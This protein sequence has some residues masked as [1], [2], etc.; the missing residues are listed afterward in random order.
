MARPSYSQKTSRVNTK[1]LKN[2]MRSIGASYGDNIKQLAPNISEITNAGA[3]T[4]AQVARS[5]RTNKSGTERVKTA[6]SSNKYVKFATTAY[7]N[8]LVDIKTGNFNNTERE[9]SSFGSQISSEIEDTIGGFTFGDDGADNVNV[10]VIGDSGAS[11]GALSKQLADNSAASLQVQKANMDAYVAVSSASMQQV[12]QIG[13]EIVNQLSNV[14]NQL[15]AI[16]QYNNS[17]M[18]K[19]IEASMA[20]MER[21][22]SSVEKMSA[23]GGKDD[24]VSAM[25]VI[26]SGTK[27]GINLGRYKQMVKQQF[28][29]MVDNSEFGVL[30]TLLDD[31]MFMQQLASNPLAGLSRGLTSYMTPKIL[32]ST[33]ENM[34]TTFNNMSVDIASQLADLSK[35]TSS[36]FGG[37]L[38]R[39]IGETFGLKVD[40][41]NTF[42]GAK[43][44]RGAIPFDGETKHAITEIITKELRTQT[45]YLEIIA[46]HY[47][48]NAKSKAKENAEVWDWDSNSYIKLGSITDKITEQMMSTITSTMSDSFFGSN[49]NGLIDQQKNDKAKKD[50]ESTINELYVYMEK[51]A[52][53]LSLPDLLNYVQATN[54]SKEAKRA[55]KNWIKY[56]KEQNP[57]DFNSRTT[58]QISTQ[59]AMKELRDE[60]ANNPTYYHLFDSEYANAEDIDEIFLEQLG[61]TGP[62]KRNRGASRVNR[63]SLDGYEAATR[64]SKAAKSKSFSNKGKTEWG[65]KI[66]GAI[67][68]K[69]NHGINIANSM[70]AGDP[71]G[72]ASG[73]AQMVT[74]SFM[75]VTKNV[76]KALFGEKDQNSKLF[77]GGILSNVA[78]G[79]GDMVN[80][81]KYKLTGKG[82]TDSKGNNHADTDDT[83]FGR[84][85]NVGNTIKDAVVFKLFGKTKNNDGNYV[86]TGHGVADSIVEGFKDAGRSFKELLFGETDE[87]GNKSRRNAGVIEN[88]KKA[89]Q[90]GFYANRK[91]SSDTDDEAQLSDSDLM[92]KALG[93]ASIGGLLGAMVGGPVLGAMAGLAVSITKNSDR[94]RTILFGEKDGLTLKNGGRADKQGVVGVI[95]NYFKS[96][97][98][99]PLKHELEYI[100]QDMLSSIKHDILSPIGFGVEFAV[101]KIGAMLSPLTNTV[102]EGLD[103]VGGFFGGTLRKMFPNVVDAG[104][105]IL[106]KTLHLAYET[107]SKIVKAPFK[108]V[109]ATVK[110]LGI[111]DKVTQLF[112]TITKPILTGISGIFG[113]TKGLVK[114]AFHIVS[115]PVR[116]VKNV[117]GKGINAVKGKVRN[118]SQNS[119]LGKIRDNYNSYDHTLDKND[120]IITEASDGQF[121]QDTSEARQWLID[122]GKS[123]VLSQLDDTLSIRMKINSRER[124]AEHKQLKDDR[125][126][127]SLSDKNAKK[128]AKWTKGQFGEDSQEAREWLKLHDRNWKQHEKELSSEGFEFA[129]ERAEEAR[130]AREG[131]SSQG[132]DE[133]QLSRAQLATMSETGQT[134]ALL[135]RIYNQLTGK[136]ED[137]D[138]NESNGN[139]NHNNNHGHNNQNRNSNDE[140][141]DDGEEVLFDDNDP[142]NVGRRHEWQTIKNIKEF[143][144]FVKNIFKRSYAKGGKT[145]RGLSLVG[146]TGP[147]LVE[148]A[149]GE[150][151]YN[152]NTTR[153]LLGG[154]G[155]GEDI[156]DENRLSRKNTASIIANSSTD[157]RQIARARQEQTT[158]A[159]E[160]ATDRRLDSAKAAMESA[161]TAKEQQKEKEDSKFKAALMSVVEKI[162]G[163]VA[164]TAEETKSHSIA[165]GKIFSKK[166]ILTTLAVAGGALLIKYFPGIITTVGKVIGTIA[167]GIGWIFNK[168]ITHDQADNENGQTGADVAKDIASNVKD[169]NILQLNDDGSASSLTEGSAKVLARTGLNIWQGKM[170]AKLGL[171]KATTGLSKLASHLPGVG[172][173]SKI[174][175]VERQIGYTGQKVADSKFG[176]AI[177]SKI[178]NAFVGT[179]EATKLGLGSAVGFADD[180]TRLM[181]DTAAKKLYGEGAD[182]ALAMA[183]DGVTAVSTKG[184]GLITKLGQTKAGQ[185]VTSAVSSAKSKAGDVA[186]SALNAVD[187]K[188][189]TKLATE[190]VEEGVESGAKTGKDTIKKWIGKFYTFIKEKFSSKVG[191]ELAET[192]GQKVTQKALDAAVDK[193]SNTKIVQLVS[194]ITGKTTADVAAATLTFGLSEVAMATISAVNGVSGTAKLF[195]CKSDDV[196]ATMKIVAGI[197]GALTGTTLGSI[198]D[199]IFSVLSAVMGVDILNGIAVWMYKAIVGADSEKAQNLEDSQAELYSDYQSERDSKVE[200]QYETQKKAGLID[201][202]MTLDEFKEGVN[203]GTVSAKYEGFDNYNTRV[204]GSWGDKAISAV[205]KGLKSAGAGI[206]KGFHSVF[207]G[208]KTYT[209]SNGNTYTKN[210]DGTYQVKSADGEDLGYVSKDAIPKDATV[211][212]SKGLVQK[213]GAG[214]A[215]GVSNVAGSIGEKAT[216]LKTKLSE[217]ASTAVDSIKGGISDLSEKLS[218]IGTS[219]TEKFTTFKSATTDIVSNVKDFISGK[220]DDISL[221]SSDD[222]AD[223]PF[224][225]I[226]N[227]AGGVLKVFLSPIRLITK[228]FGGISDTVS[229]ITSTV[230]DTASNIANGVKDK[231]SGITDKVSNGWNTVKNG[232]SAL[233]NKFTGG[234]GPG[235]TLNGGTYY[236]QSDSRWGNGA[237]GF[238][239]ATMADSGC[240][241]TAAAMAFS[242]VTGQSVSPTSMANLAQATGNRDNT[243]TNWNFI[244][245]AASSMGMNSTQIIRPN[246]GDITGALSSGNPVILSGRSGGY[247]NSPYTRAGH[248]V[249]ATGMDRN[250]NVLINDPRGASYSGKYNLND[251]LNTTGSIWSFGGRGVSTAS[252]TG[253]KDWLSVVKACKNS[254]GIQ[255]KGYSQSGY[256][257]VN[258][259]GK[260]INTRRDCSGFVSVCLSFYTGEK[261]L[262]SSSGFMSG[263]NVE[264]YL[265]KHGFSKYDFPGW[266]KVKAGDILVVKGHVEISAE[267]GSKSVYNCGSNS[268]CNNPGATKSGHKT[269]TYVWRPNNAGTGGENYA[270]NSV[271][272]TDDGTSTTTTT[273][274]SNG[275]STSILS[276]VSNFMS[277][278][279]TKALN[280]LFGGSYDTDYSDVF[281]TGSTTTTTTTSSGS[282]G[283]TTGAIT[284]DSVSAAALSKTESMSK[285]WKYLRNKGLSAN[286]VAGIMGNLQAES[287]LTSNNLQNSGNKKLGMTDE[288]YTKAVNNGSYTNFGS[289]RIGY[290]LAQWTSSNRKKALWDLAKSKGKSI[291][292]LDVQLDYLWSELNGSYKKNVLTPLQQNGI[293]ITDASN[294]VL[295]KFE[296]PKNQS[297]SVQSKRASLGKGVYEQMGGAGIGARRFA[298]R[299]TTIIRGGRGTGTSSVGSIQNGTG[300]SSM[301]SAS[302]YIESNKNYSSNEL[303][304]KCI[305]LLAQ[306]VTNTGSA[307]DKLDLLNNLS[308]SL[309][310][311]TTNNVSNTNKSGAAT[312]FKSSSYADATA[313]KIAQGG[314]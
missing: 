200:E 1:W 153:L 237:Y 232:A 113:F 138:E 62:N 163:S 44:E 207:G 70:M 55:V 124:K 107:T 148:F 188:I 222:S 291:S 123:D 176:K 104:G 244:N 15:A 201:S 240:G 45:Q 276:T 234:S 233:W 174:K 311:S 98:V 34:E 247:G 13:A 212:K 54:G 187:D 210:S 84:L 285:I 33:I 184:D 169:G 110:A 202:N 171:N 94:F 68:R 128:I 298:P 224:S 215:K 313:R 154:R 20:Y 151:V 283:S 267:N 93:N 100:G 182:A 65:Q 229:G 106:T 40:R 180:G 28:K 115:T 29:H 178:K 120:Q 274:T 221:V 220:T 116:A 213:A 250:G 281:N 223:N 39:A 252:A 56:M 150:N 239:G 37:M 262:T 71:I 273:T 18:N 26:A 257:D 309:N 259:D 218:T 261:I 144:S 91:K 147:E 266:D 69:V 203:N 253:K 43:V 302:N 217:G 76:S 211:S 22:G 194:K 48:R 133:S 196:D 278:F 272:G 67:T 3:R 25:D 81:M 63:K 303:M 7:K 80:S 284:D 118:A 27:G 275:G 264:T 263:S 132:M 111:T 23:G 191:G 66:T 157:K 73:Y 287:G 314:Y 236:S 226:L 209:D 75:S 57:E 142:E 268:S 243:G 129:K 161:K 9:A 164:S 295:T 121:T 119:L 105:N 78:N 270:T 206:A 241:P 155:E 294:V 88:V 300:Y 256:I 304:V 269:Y 258:V 231:V 242:D 92:G 160:E 238:D 85:Q 87:D 299:N 42:K 125:R 51:N 312:Q 86:K 64:N 286:A 82:Y 117:V 310:I 307:S 277:S 205:G 156:S 235:M 126:K 280:G 282:D 165:W 162:Q 145:R 219:L 122:N 135:A 21:V 8:A 167:K 297:A 225:S 101:E 96:G 127:A 61:L 36:S 89:F 248:Y 11:L 83:V 79:F 47:N 228:V 271:A 172:I 143:G 260:T 24:K 102:K 49:L 136:N 95:G 38:K 279:A 305:N 208:E 41:T 183:Q 16:V 197:I 114:D 204:N 131:R 292:D 17:S 141:E 227:I 59:N 230:T 158:I 190:T 181:T 290:G 50:V 186:K 308:G 254:I 251:I 4:A 216:E 35:D 130:I 53:H 5:L 293:S 99:D 170:A 103:T 46:S 137:E 149:G 60:M 31:D 14:N 2:A 159:R 112:K 301:T 177:G 168:I 185:A 255:K 72:V 265:K 77:E 195:K 58:A 52:E 179:S 288:E 97:V 19:Y 249:V 12:G 109:S 199:L 134:N 175:N 189:T 306:I 289:D 214:I 74:D 108:L 198:I 146:E 6:L 192:S 140:D 245:D 30:K 139:N 173:G 296:K 246:A 152:S 90:K 193:L 166:G 32:K 10:N